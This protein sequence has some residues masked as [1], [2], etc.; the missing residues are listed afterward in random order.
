MGTGD[1][2]KESRAQTIL[3]HAH[4]SA[5]MDLIGKIGPITAII[6]K[7]GPITSNVEHTGHTGQ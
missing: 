6:G 7:I 2:Q 4:S 1:P 3:N 5:P